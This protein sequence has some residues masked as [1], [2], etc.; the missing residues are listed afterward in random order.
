MTFNAEL[1]ALPQRINPLFVTA[2]ILFEWWDKTQREKW[3]CI[4]N[5]FNGFCSYYWLN[6]IIKPT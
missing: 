1:I 6:Q 5:E 4:N 3:K 2:E